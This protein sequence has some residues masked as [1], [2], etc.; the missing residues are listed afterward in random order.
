MKK[1]S[2]KLSSLLLALCLLLSLLPTTVLAADG[3]ETDWSLDSSGILTISSDAGMSDWLTSGNGDFSNSGSV[4][5]VVVGGT[6]TTINAG[7]F[8]NRTNITSVTLGSSVTTIGEK[9]FY[10][11]GVITVT[12]PASVTSIG[13]NAFYSCT[14]LSSV[15]FQ[16]TTV[17]STIG[18]A[19]FDTTALTGIYVPLDS[20]SDYK[21]ALSIYSYYI[22]AKSVAITNNSATTYYKTLADALAAA[23]D[24]ETITLLNDI[25]ESAIY[26]GSEGKTITVDGQ[27]HTVTGATVDTSIA[28]M[29]GGTD[30]FILKNLTLQGNGVSSGIGLQ[31]GGLV[32]I[33]SCG[34][35]NV[36]GG[37]A[38]SSIGLN[39]FSA[40]TVDLTGAY[41]PGSSSGIGVYSDSSGTVNVGT[42]EGSGTQSGG[43]VNTSSGTV[44]VTEATGYTFGVLNQSDGTINVSTVTC[45]S[46]TAVSNAGSGTINAGI[47]NGTDNVD[48][49]VVTLN[50][51]T[52]A[53]CVLGSIT[54]AADTA[55]STTIGSLPGVFKND[56]YS[57]T[58]YTDSAKNT[59][60]SGTSVAGATTLYSS[61]YEAPASSVSIG[62]GTTSSTSSTSSSDITTTTAGSVTTGTA[63]V[64]GTTSG[65]TQTVTVT[66]STMTSLTGAAETAESAGG[67]AIANISTGTGT[68]LTNVGVTIPGTQFKAFA[69]GTDAALRFTTGIGT[70]TFSS[71]A[72]DTI[73]AA[74]SGDVVFGMSI[75]D[76]TTL[77]AQAQAAVGDRPVYSFSL[78]VG[79]TTVSEFGGSVT[80]SLPYT[81]GANEDP[82]A[83][84]VYYLDASGSLQLMQGI[85]DTATGT[86]TFETTHFSDYVIGYNM[87]SFTDVADTAWY[88]DA[89]TF[90]AARGITGGTT[91]TT[92]SPDA[93]LTRGQF[94]VMLM[95]AYGLDAD[96][97]ASDNFSD[98]GDTY[99]TGYLAAAKLLGI[100]NGVGDNMFAPEQ[101][102]TRQEMFTLPL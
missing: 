40:G 22:S 8:Q 9:A 79:G 78:T 11:C 23:A 36:S 38:L 84:V 20:L 102:I 98:A 97:D 94:I 88:Y 37:E 21:T 67:Q 24:G 29:L 33:R 45:S 92:F 96:D 5:S 57:D 91:D 2:K 26:T 27:N 73:A 4:N 72:V 87:V 15:I 70:I 62:G 55:V 48:V 66:S 68:N 56:A 16:G 6:T 46:G 85:Y 14:S 49:A 31:T 59:E 28:L 65:T 18:E 1:I 95:R 80:V 13:N 32:C 58:W 89:V 47:I 41:G 7:A 52:G 54:V 25:T 63:T 42:A 76:T 71:D 86:V 90:I 3:T 10:G 44:N 69:S 93:T 39:N 61:F 99:Y 101:A 50:A 77:S 100:T 17:P 53:S 74:G 75:V 43:V 64:T 12:I 30:T 60:F 34:T 51:G 83:I 81:L 35:V 82:N 19:I